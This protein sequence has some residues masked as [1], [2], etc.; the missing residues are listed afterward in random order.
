[1]QIFLQIKRREACW[2]GGQQ[3]EEMERQKKNAGSL[4]SLL[5]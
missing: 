2:I 3:I 1:M 4:I 5:R